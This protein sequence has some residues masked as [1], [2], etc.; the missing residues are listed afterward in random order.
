M[1]VIFVATVNAT[2]TLENGKILGFKKIIESESPS[3]M[4]DALWFTNGNDNSMPST[5]RLL[6]HLFDKKAAF[7]GRNYTI[8][9]RYEQ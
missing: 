3:E 8:T 6:V 7:C 9:M 2:L 5:E 1:K 4:L